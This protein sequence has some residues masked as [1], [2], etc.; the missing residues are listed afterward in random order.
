MSEE[1]LSGPDMTA[2]L[3]K[4]CA[5]LMEMFDAIQI[6]ATCHDSE[7]NQTTF[8]Y[9]GR[10]NVFA[11]RGLA[12]EYLEGPLPPVQEEEDDD[13]DGEDWKEPCRT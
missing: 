11:R 2:I 8:F 4:H 7:S 5:Q 12:R 6:L 13:D 1:Y 10:G 9:Q 3:K